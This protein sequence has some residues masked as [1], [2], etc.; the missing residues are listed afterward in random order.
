MRSLWKLTYYRTFDRVAEQSRSDQGERL[1]RSY[2]ALFARKG[3]ERVSCP[4]TAL[5]E[6]GLKRDKFFEDTALPARSFYVSRTEDRVR[7]GFFSKKLEDCRSLRGRRRRGGGRGVRLA[8]F[9][10]AILMPGFLFNVLLLFQLPSLLPVTVVSVRP[11][12]L[13]RARQRNFL[14]PLKVR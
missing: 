11:R 6:I 1:P 7:R 13:K 10:S 3:C 8:P 12:R 14:R 9:T 4:E 5:C 2:R